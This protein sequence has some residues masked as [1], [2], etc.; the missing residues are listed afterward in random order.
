MTLT[1]GHALEPS[2]VDTLA[3]D[4]AARSPQIGAAAGLVQADTLALDRRGPMRPAALSPA[5]SRLTGWT[6]GVIFRA[7]DIG[8]L[9]VIALAG[10]VIFSGGALTAA[11]LAPFV[12]GAI[13]L[14]WSLA[15][16]H[17]YDFA[18]RERLVGHLTRLA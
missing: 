3:L 15:S 9:A 16:L 7:A 13:I 4:N 1:L 18:P 17:A 14:I 6:L 11:S 5:R 10:S 2:Q 12:V 8:A